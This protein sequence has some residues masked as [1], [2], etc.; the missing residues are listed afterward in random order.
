[1]ARRDSDREDLMREATALRERIEIAVD[2]EVGPI[3]AGFRDGGA[4]S[5]YFGADPV[6]HFDAHGRFRRAFAGGALYRT[7][8]E[9]LARLN[10]ERDVSETRLLRHDL[11]AAE[12]DQFHKLLQERLRQLLQPL[13]TGDFR[14]LQQVPEDA[15][16]CRRVQSALQQALQTDPWLA[17]AIR[18]KR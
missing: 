9:T 1:M 18:G 10:R 15:D 13:A 8:G 3:V 5:V 12:L 7:Q 16:I 17:P 14:V 4:L 11:N 6:F 2:G